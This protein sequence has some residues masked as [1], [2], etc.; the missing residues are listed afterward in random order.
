VEAVA[1]VDGLD[2]IDGR[3]GSFAK[4]GYL[5]QPWGSVEIDGFRQSFDEVAAFRFGAVSESY[6]AKKGDDRN[7]GVVGVAFFAEEGAP[8]P[9]TSYELERRREA[10]PFPGR[11]A[12]PP[13]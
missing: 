4:R 7:V 6:A 9:W 12:S 3:S 2:V 8:Y 10:N 1:T 5:I 11:F 13:N